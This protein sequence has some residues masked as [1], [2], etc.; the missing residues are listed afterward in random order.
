MSI[1]SDLLAH[2]QFNG[3]CRDS[4]GNGN[5]GVNHGADLSAAGRDGTS[6]GA[7]GFDGRTACVTVPAGAS[8][9]LGSSD[10]TLAAGV[11][12]PP[13]GAN[14]HGDILSKFDPATRTG[15]NFGTLNYAGVTAAQCTPPQSALRHR[16]RR[17]RAVMG[18]L[19]PAGQ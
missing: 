12:L 17:A 3:D 9:A 2:W 19:R 14:L 5:H 13:D 15:L 8:L 18:R 7:A 11:Q 1:N 16:R 4:S 10:F 6:G